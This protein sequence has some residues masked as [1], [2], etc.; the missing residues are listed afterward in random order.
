MRV[1]WNSE[2][3]DMGMSMSAG[4]LASSRITDLFG[5]STNTKQRPNAESTMLTMIG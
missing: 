4:S 3:S 5:C 2:G 1:G